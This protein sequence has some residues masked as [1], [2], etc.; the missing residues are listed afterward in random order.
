MQTVVS[1]LRAVCALTLV[2]TIAACGGGGIDAGSASGSANGGNTGTTG[3]NAKTDTS[4]TASDQPD[5]HFAP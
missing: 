2:F 3:V 4:S 1:M 5:V